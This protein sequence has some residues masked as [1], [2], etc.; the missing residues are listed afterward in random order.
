M[1]S[2]SHPSRHAL[3][4]RL[5]LPH[6]DP[7]YAYDPT[8]VAGQHGEIRISPGVA[9]HCTCGG[10][11]PDQVFG[12]DGEPT[13]CA[14]RPF[15]MAI[16]QVDKLITDSGMPGR[17]QYKFLD[18]FVEAYEGEPI[19]GASLL[20]QQ[21]R[22]LIDRFALQGEAQASAPPPRGFLLWG[23]PGNGKTHFACT[24]LNELIFHT[25]RPG[26]FISISRKFF[27]T[28]RHTFDDDSPIRGQAIPILETLGA[29]PFLVID[30]F[31]VQRDTE[32]EVEMLY[33]LI[34]ARY[35]EQRLTLVTTN[36]RID[37]IKDLANGRI[38]S[39]FLEMCH[40]VHVTAPDF[41]E[42]FRKE[43]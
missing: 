29:V 26:R 6:G 21:L 10:R 27:Q 13:W 11:A 18:D 14:C 22:P 30:D 4:E 3:R 12:E 19:P 32:W 40:I 34:D 7:G 15:R 33:N 28:L 9:A 37:D 41:R 35:A 43:F 24:A 20:K 25:G 17:F 39:R 42:H 1:N 8:V 23:N 2:T 38:Y 36:R 5:G 31:G 16:R